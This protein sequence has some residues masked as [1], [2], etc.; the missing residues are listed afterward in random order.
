MD[1]KYLVIGSWIDKTTGAPVSR[2]GEITGGLN[3]NNQPFEMVNTDTYE[4]V[5]GTYPVGTV[6]TASFT[7]TV[8]E[9]PES[10]RG[11]KLGTSK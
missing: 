4:T 6:L 11:L 10:P 2:I 8:Q 9:R 1:K 7:L 3:K 5:E